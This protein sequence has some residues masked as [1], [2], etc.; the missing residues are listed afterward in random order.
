L[1]VPPNSVL[2]STTDQHHGRIRFS[3]S[4]NDYGCDRQLQAPRA[5]PRD[6]GRLRRGAVRLRPPWSAE[7]AEQPASAGQPAFAWPDRVCTQPPRAGRIRREEAH[8]ALTH[9]NQEPA[10][11]FQWELWQVLWA[12]LIAQILPI[13]RDDDGMTTPE[14]SMLGNPLHY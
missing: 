6:Q 5:A 10:D 12:G 4:R 13:N 1:N 11:P 8:Q 3:R 14:L 2:I 9:G 7:L